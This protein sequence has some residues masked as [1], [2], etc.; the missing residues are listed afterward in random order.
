MFPQVNPVTIYTDGACTGN[1]GSGGYGAVILQDGKRRE[2]SKGYQMT[3]NNRMELMAAIAALESLKQSSQV[4]LFT[5]S[6]YLSD[7]INKGWTDTW[8]ANGWRKSDK[9]KVLNMDLWK[10]LLQLLDKHDVRILWVKG[11]AGHKENERCDQLAVQ[12]AQGK[13]LAQDSGYENS[14]ESQINRQPG[15]F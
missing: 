11:H 3:T 5:D 15:L 1:P 7:A 12:A 4:R 9:G 14:K 8:Q 10:R 6:K 2:L 13:N